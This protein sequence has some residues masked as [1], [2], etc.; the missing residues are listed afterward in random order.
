VFGHVAV[1][2]VG[3]QR[4]AAVGVD[5]ENE[6]VAGLAE[7]VALETPQGPR[8]RTVRREAFERIDIGRVQVGLRVEPRRQTQY[9]F[10]DVHRAQA[11]FAA[12]RER[13]AGGLDR[14]ERRQLA[15]PDPAEFKRR[16]RLQQGAREARTFAPHA[17]R[18]ESEA[19]MVA[20][21]AFDEKTRLAVR[22]RVQ[23]P[24]RRAVDAHQPS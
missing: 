19:A 6:A 4:L 2:A 3:H 24:A 22:P 11:R 17:A 12:G 8:V 15:L 18:D 23:D 13:L 16:Q 9:E 1:F 10:V 5:V 14:R 21:E 7:Q 20:R